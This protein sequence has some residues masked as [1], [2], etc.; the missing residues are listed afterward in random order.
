MARGP[1]RHEAGLFEKQEGGP[2]KRGR[3][4]CVEKDRGGKAGR[5][6]SGLKQD[7]LETVKRGSLAGR[8]LQ[9]RRRNL[10]FIVCNEES[11]VG[12]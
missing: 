3:G 6:A 11:L 12:F 8:P 10:D 9:I 5:L 7:G 1:S 2:R 4:Y